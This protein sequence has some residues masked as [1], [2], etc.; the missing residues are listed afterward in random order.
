[1]SSIVTRKI[2]RMDLENREAFLLN[3]IYAIGLRVLAGEAPQEVASL[4]TGVK[5]IIAGERGT[6]ALFA[7]SDKMKC[8]ALSISDADNRRMAADP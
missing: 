2:V 8:S 4:V 1:V 3:A 7:L 6:N 5:V